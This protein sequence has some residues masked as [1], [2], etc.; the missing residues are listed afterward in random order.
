MGKGQP[1]AQRHA[2]VIHK[3]KRGGAGAA[4]FAVD[5]DEIRGDAAVHHRLADRQKLPLM[6]DA[7]LE[8]GGLSA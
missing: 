7:E 8:A 4:L 6:P 2:D 1:I 3:L 5:H